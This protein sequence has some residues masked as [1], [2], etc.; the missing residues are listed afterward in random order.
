MTTAHT[1]GPWVARNGGSLKRSS[2]DTTWQRMI[3]DALRSGAITPE[4]RFSLHDLKRKGI[5]DT[6]GTRA[7]KQ[8]ASGHRTEAMLDVY[9]HSRP[10]V[11]PSRDG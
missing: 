11:K 8:D 3:T 10:V 2:L 6:E 7:D 9:D 1:P 5:T 4:Q